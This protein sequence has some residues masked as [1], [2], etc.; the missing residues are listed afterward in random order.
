MRPSRRIAQ[1]IGVVAS[2]MAL[3]G[4]ALLSGAS[5]LTVGDVGGDDA[6]PTTNAGGNLDGGGTA[7]GAGMPNFDGGGGRF[8]AGSD[9]DAKASPDGGAV[10][11]RLRNVTFEDGTLTGVHGGDSAFGTPF[12]TGSAAA[13]D[14]TASLSVDKGQ[15]G[16]QVDVPTLTEVYATALLRVGSLSFSS[17]VTVLAFVPESGGTIAELHLE[18]SV[19]GG[20]FA[21]DVGG[22]PVGSSNGVAANTVYRVGFHLRQNATSHLIEVFVAPA[23]MA[24]GA[25]FA[26]SAVM[27]GRTIGVRMGDLTATTTS[28]KLVFD[29]LLIDT[30]AMPGL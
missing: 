16:I 30:A 13:I 6:A 2:A 7:D 25:P 18:A 10:G 23:G 26:T 19:V 20:T 8:D 3:A 5:D 1:R 29:D 28:S 12:L 14:G 9:V 24:F 15:A 11:A 21:V 27:L 17:D 22:I 4:C